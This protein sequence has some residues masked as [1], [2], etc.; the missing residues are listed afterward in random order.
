MAYRVYKSTLGRADGALS[1][2]TPQVH[3]GFSLSRGPASVVFTPTHIE[4]LAGDRLRVVSAQITVF[5]E[6]VDTND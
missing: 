3:Q 2:N 6:K 5:L 4:E 1:E